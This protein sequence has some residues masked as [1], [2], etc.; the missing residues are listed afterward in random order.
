M[1]INCKENFLW[2]P[3]PTC[4]DARWRRISVPIRNQILLTLFYRTG[5]QFEKGIEQQGSNG[6]RKTNN[7]ANDMRGN[8]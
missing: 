4:L 1:Q 8:S 6:G 2:K 5:Q 7:A 3:P